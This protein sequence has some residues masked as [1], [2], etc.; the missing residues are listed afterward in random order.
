VGGVKVDAR[1][2]KWTKIVTIVS[3][4]PFRSGINMQ[5][6]QRPKM[7]WLITWEATG[8]LS[9][10]KVAGIISSRFGNKRLMNLIE[11]LYSSYSY[12]ATEMLNIAVGRSQNPY[13]A[14]QT[15]T[16]QNELRIVCGHNPFLSARKIYD[17][18]IK[19]DQL[20]RNTTSR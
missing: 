9:E 11:N 10:N 2:R 3:Q 7:V 12:S 18:E 1:S 20:D 19:L 14:E 6:K 5:R 15:F 17:T 4:S 8:S 16:K 13:P